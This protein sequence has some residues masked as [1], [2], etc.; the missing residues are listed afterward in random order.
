MLAVEHAL[1]RLHGLEP[2][3]VRRI[4]WRNLNQLVRK[5]GRARLMNRRIRSYL[6]VGSE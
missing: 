1:A 5:N 3:K 4:T 2:G 6:I